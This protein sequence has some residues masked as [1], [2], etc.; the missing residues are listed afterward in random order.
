MVDEKE[1]LKK[2]YEFIKTVYSLDNKIHKYKQ[3]KEY[4][5]DIKNGITLLRFEN[6]ISKNNI[7]K[8]VIELVDQINC[9][10]QTNYEYLENYIITIDTIINDIDILI[11]NCIQDK[12]KEEA[13][14]KLMEV[15]DNYE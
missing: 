10:Y 4:L 12:L 7:D 8:I 3:E 13:I 9:K 14:K 15:F 5:Q 2:I 11:N 1:I 6:K